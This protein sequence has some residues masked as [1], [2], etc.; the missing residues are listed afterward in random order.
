LANNFLNYTKRNSISEIFEHLD[1]PK[2]AA[3][4]AL[5]KH[6]LYKI[7]ATKQYKEL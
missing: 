3:I 5:V 2:D 7:D 4:N 6:E 1:D